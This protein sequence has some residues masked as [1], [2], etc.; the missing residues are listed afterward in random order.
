MIELLSVAQ[1]ATNGTACTS[2]T[3]GAAAA[4]PWVGGPF[5]GTDTYTIFNGG[6]WIH[7]SE[8]NAAMAVSSGVS[9]QL[10]VVNNDGAHT[11]AYKISL[12][13]VH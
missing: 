8:S 11:A 1:D 10:K 9:D 12:F 4:H 6:K 13:G 5:T 2:I 7:V 3:L